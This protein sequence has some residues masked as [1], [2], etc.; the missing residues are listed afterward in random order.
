M[1]R[2][3]VTFAQAEGAEPLPAVLAPKEVSPMLRALLWLVVK[4]SVAE[5]KYTHDP[6]KRSGF[7]I[8]GRWQE[9]L[10]HKHVIVDHRLDDFSADYGGNVYDVKKIFEWGDYLGIFGF[11]QFVIRHPKCPDGFAEEVSEALNEAR[12]AY[13]SVAKTFFPVS[14]PE[15]ANSVATALADLGASDFHG[16]RAHLL[17][18]G[19]LASQGRDAESVRESIHAVESVARLLDPAGQHLPRSCPHAA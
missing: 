5:T 16:A 17:Q 4:T 7:K 14:T 2:T 1:D 11:L 9:T 10:F 3:K 18:A 15:E 19:E 12:A 13:T 6:F 8:G